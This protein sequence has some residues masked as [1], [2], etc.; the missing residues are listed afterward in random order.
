MEKIINSGKPLK[1]CKQCNEEYDNYKLQTSQY[2]SGTCKNLWEKANKKKVDIPIP[3]VNTESFPAPQSSGLPMVSTNK[4]QA[5]GHV[6]MYLYNEKIAEINQL[7]LKVDAYQ[8]DEKAAAKE[9]AALEKQLAVKEASKEVPATLGGVPA[10]VITT[11]FNNPESIKAMFEGLGSIMGK[12]K[13]MG[14]ATDN[15]VLQLLAAASPEIQQQ[16][17]VVFQYLLTFPE[18]LTATYNVIVAAKNTPS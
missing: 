6:P 8:R 12:G 3:P 10:D 1:T 11:I 9:I 17:A 2:C 18:Q 5:D 14:G 7:R 4:V 15:A 13:Q 16:A